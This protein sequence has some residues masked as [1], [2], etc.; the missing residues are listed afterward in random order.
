MK[1][2]TTNINNVDNPNETKHIILIRTTTETYLSKSNIN[3]VTIP[4]E[5]INDLINTKI[6]NKNRKS[7]LQYRQK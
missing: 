7:N 6:I 2:K 4:S 3:F 1:I 5:A